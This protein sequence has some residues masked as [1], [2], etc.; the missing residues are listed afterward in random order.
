[1]RIFKYGGEL[2]PATQTPFVKQ[3]DCRYV[4]D[5][6]I[7]LPDACSAV[8]S[9]IEIEFSMDVGGVLTVNCYNPVEER[10]LLYSHV[11][12]AIYGSY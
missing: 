10:E 8:G 4:Y 6:H 5:L 1:M 2:P 7:E 11:Y 3:E 9:F 12:E